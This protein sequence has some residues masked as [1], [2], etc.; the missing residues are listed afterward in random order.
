MSLY[1]LVTP[2]HD[3]S[4][5]LTSTKR[6][7]PLQN[8][9]PQLLSP[10]FVVEFPPVLCCI[11]AMPLSNFS[12]RK[13]TR[14]AFRLATSSFSAFVPRRTGPSFQ[15]LGDVPKFRRLLQIHFFVSTKCIILDDSSTS[16][17]IAGV[18]RFGNPQIRLLVVY[19]YI[20]VSSCF[21]FFIFTCHSL[22][23]RTPWQ[24]RAT[25]TSLTSPQKI[26]KEGN[27]SLFPKIQVGE[28]LFGQIHY[29]N[30]NTCGCSLWQTFLSVIPR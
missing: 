16:D 21:A 3:H 20:H 11:G 2:Q 15:K 4:R 27:I 25:R 5:T 23:S 1:V 10:S 12:R 24:S 17:F 9:N 8:P 14:R 30:S 26:A 22:V 6:P 18:P 28:I 29:T 13:K 19:I 7:L